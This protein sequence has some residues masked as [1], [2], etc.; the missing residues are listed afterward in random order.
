LKLCGTKWAGRLGVGSS[1]ELANI[2]VLVA[3][4][5]PL[6]AVGV[7]NQLA[8]AGATVVGPCSTSGRAI[9]ALDENDID[10]AIIDF[11]LADDNT[12]GL[13]AALEDKGIPYIVV[14]GYPRV[15]VRRDRH[16]PVLSKPV[17]REAL[18]STVRALS[19]A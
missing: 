13:Q 17:S 4:D 2:T 5:E 14:T 12:E 10:V 6:V 8:E 3:E 16:Q 18:T 19:G 1:R 15:L 7:V 9:A 11:V